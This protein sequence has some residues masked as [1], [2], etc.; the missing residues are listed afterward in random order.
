MDAASPQ[1]AASTDPWHA[2]VRRNV[3]AFFAGRGRAGTRDVQEPAA[4]GDGSDGGASVVGSL[5]GSV[6]D[7]GVGDSIVGSR[8]EHA[9]D[10]VEGSVVD[11]EGGGD[12][13]GGGGGAVQPTPFQPFA[14]L[15]S[16]A[17]NTRQ[18]GVVGGAGASGMQ[19][20]RRSGKRRHRQR[21]SSA[22]SDASSEA[23]SRGASPALAQSPADMMRRV[24]RSTV[25]GR[26]SGG[27]AA[28]FFRHPVASTALC[29][30]ALF[31]ALF[32]AL[33]ITQPRW[34]KTRKWNA[35]GY[36]TLR[37]RWRRVA[38][39]SFTG[40]LALAVLYTVGERALQAKRRRGA[41]PAS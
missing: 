19:P 20:S 31:L 26:E 37:T 10:G 14:S 15:S 36:Y 40:G 38:W 23:V 34:L 4:A 32:V 1:P 35:A 24:L 12:G 29:G 9:E 25:G 22:A 18:L 39:V 27:G 6:D 33:G 17:M 30:M 13:G 21:A 11:E 3:Q 5:A 41:R 16:A 7:D 8:V 2:I 28:A